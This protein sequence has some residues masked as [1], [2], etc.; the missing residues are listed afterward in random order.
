MEFIWTSVPLYRVSS[1]QDNTLQGPGYMVHITPCTYRKVYIGQMRDTLTWDWRNK[2]AVAEYSK[3]IQNDFNCHK[4]SERF[5]HKKYHEPE[6]HRPV[7]SNQNTIKYKYKSNNLIAC[8]KI[9][10]ENWMTTLETLRNQSRGDGNQS[11]NC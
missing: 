4:N 9:N 1:K 11:E 7:I 6:Y 10:A 3:K 2:L 8:F 5:I